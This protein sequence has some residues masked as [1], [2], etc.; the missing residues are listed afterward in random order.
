MTLPSANLGDD[1]ASPADEGFVGKYQARCH[2]G[3]VRCEVAAD[4]VDARICHCR[5]WQ[6]LHGAP[7]PW[8]AIFHKRDVRFLA[9]V[10]ELRFYSSARKRLERVLSCKV[11]CGACGTPIADEGRTVWL[12]FPALFDFGSPPAVPAAFR[13]TCHIFHGSHVLEVEG[14]VSKWSG[15]KGQSRRL[16]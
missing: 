1:Y 16:M 4:P 11:S 10:E 13:P 6:V 5:G 7:L 3:L 2:C 15:H 8:A 12:A 14:D 9:G